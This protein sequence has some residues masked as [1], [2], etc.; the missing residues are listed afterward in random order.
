VSFVFLLSSKSELF[1]V[2]CFFLEKMT[3]EEEKGWRSC[4]SSGGGGGGGGRRS[5]VLLT[6]DV[7]GTLLTGNHLHHQAFAHAFRTVFS[8]EASISEVPHHGTLR[9]HT[10]TTQSH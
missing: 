2:F 3:T 1:F 5:Q 6:F 10:H 4:D 8:V 7:D 9:K